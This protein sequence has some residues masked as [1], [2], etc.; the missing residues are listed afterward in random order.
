MIFRPQIE[1]SLKEY[2]D[3]ENQ[4]KK[5]LKKV[6]IVYIDDIV[7]KLSKKTINKNENLDKIEKNLEQN[8]IKIGEKDNYDFN[9]DFDENPFKD[10]LIGGGLAAGAILNGSLF[11]G[12]GISTTLIGFAA[13]GIGL[14]IAIPGFIGLGIYKIVSL[15]KDKNR[16]EFFK[17]FKTDKMKVER[18]VQAYAL[19]KIEHYFNKYISI[20]DQEVKLKYDECEKYINNII[21]IYIE[22]DNNNLNSILLELD[23]KDIL[24]KLKN[25]GEILA[26]NISKIRQEIMKTILSCPSKN[27]KDLF[28]SSVPLF[29]EFIKIFGPSN[30]EEKTEKKINENIIK[31][32]TIM[33]CILDKKMDIAL[34]NFKLKTYIKSFETYLMK[35]YEEKKLVD[36]IKEEDFTDNC[37]DYLIEP[38]GNNAKYYGILCLFFKFTILIQD[39]GSKKKKKNYNQNKDNIKKKILLANNLDFNKKEL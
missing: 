23:Q 31:I 8:M 30:I 2:V 36:N 3:S 25:D 10:A 34:D 33:R 37:N 12:L 9:L 7:R 6:D 24:Y 27:L 35:K 1:E 22:K 20:E 17:D 38:I 39:I 29:K 11:I 26:K 18:E 28:N 32:L 13:S 14:I 4:K 21:D 15:V 19:L 16:K 5:F